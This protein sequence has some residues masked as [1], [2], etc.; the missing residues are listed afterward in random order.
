MSNSFRNITINSISKKPAVLTAK[1][2]ISDF[3]KREVNGIYHREKGHDVVCLTEVS[4]QIDFRRGGG[5]RAADKTQSDV[6][7]NKFLSKRL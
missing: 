2:T 5:I 7:A 1:D 6:I 3:G 4:N